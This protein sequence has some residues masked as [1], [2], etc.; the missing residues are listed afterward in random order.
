MPPAAAAAVPALAGGGL[1]CPK[2]PAPLLGEFLGEFLL[3]GQVA[4]GKDR[5]MAPVVTGD[6]ECSLDSLQDPP[7]RLLEDI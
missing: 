4:P 1:V 6:G 2:V 3:G 5:P 7:G